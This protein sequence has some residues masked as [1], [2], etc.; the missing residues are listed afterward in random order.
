M[1]TQT[2]I[3]GITLKAFATRVI[4]GDTFEAEIRFN[5]KVRLLRVNTPEKKQPGW[6][7]F[8]NRL[9]E[10]IFG[11]CYDEFPTLDPAEITLFIPNQKPTTLLDVVT[12]D[13]FLGEV[14]VDGQNIN[15]ILAKEIETFKAKNE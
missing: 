1:N 11:V 2:P 10:L 8:K 3:E 9:K 13:R 7:K 5:V 15:D 4:D 6:L 12:F 14:W